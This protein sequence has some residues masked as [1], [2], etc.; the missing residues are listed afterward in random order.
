MLTS[1]LNGRVLADA[2][3]DG[4]PRVIALHGWARDRNDWR[5]V[6]TGV[7][8]LALDLPG[9]GLTAPPEHAW[10]SGDYARELQPLL[11]EFP[12]CVLVGHSFGGRIAAQLAVLD[13]EHVAGV[14]LTGA[15]LVR[16]GPRAK[17]STTYALIR[18]AADMGLVPQRVLERKRQRSGSSDYRQASGVMRDVLVRSVNESYDDVLQLLSGLQLPIRLVYGASDT[19]APPESARAIARLLSPADVQLTIVEGAGHQ[20]EEPLIAAL[21]AA[22]KHILGVTQTAGDT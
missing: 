4:R 7:P 14:V 18:K 16:L 11:Q 21:R 9:F 12:G 17:S 1:L 20:L 13:P 5:D 15:P 10:S 3:G 22:I 8:A 6:L 19:A 2:A